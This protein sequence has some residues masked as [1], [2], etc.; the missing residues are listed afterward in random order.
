MTE[1]QMTIA[2]L[3]DVITAANRLLFK[4]EKTQKDLEESKIPEFPSRFI[5]VKDKC[6]RDEFVIGLQKTGVFPFH[7]TELPPDFIGRACFTKEEIQQIISGLQT[8]IGDK[9]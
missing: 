8:L 7:Y 6:L 3:K 2:N 9:Q 1:L 4:L 5:A